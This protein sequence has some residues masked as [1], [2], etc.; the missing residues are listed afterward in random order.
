MLLRRF[1][2]LAIFLACFHTQAQV[3]TIPTTSSNAVRDQYQ[4]GLLKLALDKVGFK[5]EIRFTEKILSQ[6]RIIASLKDH[7]SEFDLDLYWMGTSTEL[8][9]DLI[10]I[11][12]PIYQGLLGYRVFIINKNQ[13]SEFTHQTTLKYLQ[14]KIGIQGVGWSD[15]KI[16]EAAGL[17]QKTSQYNHILTM[18]NSGSRPF[19]FSRGIHEA[20]GEI[21]AV[22]S[23]KKNLMVEKN[24]LLIYPF[25]MFFFTKKENSA[26]AKALEK[27]L[28]M[29]HEDGSF[30]KY[31]NQDPSTKQA[32]ERANIKNRHWINIKNP[33]M[34]PE[35]KAIDS[36][37]WHKLTR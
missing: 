7:S 33:F 32:L 31:F 34:S 22:K 30:H 29:A 19:Y 26:L 10:P 5:Y 8:E 1:T 37:Y 21:D 13:Q 4:I 9:K 17:K 27:G 20:F 36:R 6:S 12:F 11:R 14:S 3:I 24:I 35:T 16:L 28:K 25:A 23:D 2:L 18:I 15:I